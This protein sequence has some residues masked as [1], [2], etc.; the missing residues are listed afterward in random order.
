MNNCCEPSVPQPDSSFET[1]ARPVADWQARLMAS[2][3]RSVQA[4]DQN[5]GHLEEAILHWTR[6][7]ERK[8][9]EEA[10]Q[11]KADQSPPVCPVCGHKLSRRT[12]DQERTFHS[13]FGPVT[14]KR[15]R[16]WCRRCAAWRFPADHALGLSDTGGASPSVQEMAAL[17]VSKMPVQEASAV[18][19]RLTGVK[20]PPATLDREARR[21]GQR[22]DQQRTQL[23]EQ[24]RTV[25][26][27][28]Q[29]LPRPQAPLTLVIELDAWNIRER[30]DWGHS[31][32]KRAAGQEPS[33]W[34]W[35][36]G[37]TCFRL[38]Q[39]VTSAGG[40][41]RI[42]SCGT[43]MTRSGVAGL[44]EQ[45]F[46]EAQRHGLA[47]AAKVLVVA[48]GAVWIWNLPGDRFAQAQ[49]RL[50]YY[51]A[52]QHLWAVAHAL[53]PEAEVAARAWVQPLLKKLKGG[54]V[55]AL[56]NDLRTLAKRL[57]KKKRAAVQAEVAYLESHRERMDY[58]AARRNGEPQGSGA[59]ES[60]CRQYQCRFKRPGQFWS[61]AGDEG[62]MCL[63]TFWRNDRWQLLFPHILHGDPRKN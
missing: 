43:V 18:I 3:T 13:R 39:R 12:R 14:V 57:R 63:E 21:Q 60:T 20:L 40:R 44:R 45:L 33:R 8:L 27:A 49:Q 42:L 62:L 4:S 31:T 1:F 16:G 26:G 55:T 47:Q 6:D 48:D 15:L 54:R 28:G 59:M 51:H 24:M 30:D 11:K 34:H 37:G 17:T 53:H 41:A 19:E 61:C 10:A 32:Q 23:D 7:L 29:M 38:D 5:L 9:L 52:S 50:D 25:Q 36:Y 22:A 35:V 56:L 46:A 2:L 58:A